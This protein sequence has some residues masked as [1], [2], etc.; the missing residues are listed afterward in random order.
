MA[1][2]TKHEP[3]TF[4]WV[5]LASRNAAA[6]KRFYGSLF[7]W[8]FEDR[9]IPDGSTYT[10]ARKNGKDAVGLYQMGAHEGAIPPHW[11]SYVSVASAEKSA[12]RA[13]ELGGTVILGPFDV[14][15]HGRMAVL[16][17]PTGAF[18]SLWEPKAHIGAQVVNEPGAFCW[19]ELYTGDP[20]KAA[21]F[22][23]R[24]FGWTK[25]ARHM[26]FGEYVIFNQGGRQMAGMMQLPKEWGPV[27]PHWLVYF[28]VG[29]CDA[30][31]AKATGLGAKAMMPP[32]DIEN[33]GRFAMLTDP[34]GAGFAVI[35]LNAP[36]D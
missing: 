20:R 10:I 14:M 3:G 18:F 17:D 33:V 19:N 22:Y 29:D 15:E 8:D 4:S 5:E 7:G 2:R 12:A 23:S 34:E 21:D 9:P 16:S 1:E 32:M 24:L 30:S 11:N 28:A 31:V 6:A 36:A 35:K 27:P 25:D 26:D 13:K